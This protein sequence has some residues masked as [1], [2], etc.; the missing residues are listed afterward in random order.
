MVHINLKNRY[1]LK[2]QILFKIPQPVYNLIVDYF[3][4]CLNRNN[5]I[6]FHGPL[7]K[8]DAILLFLNWF[9]TYRVAREYG[10]K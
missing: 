4:Q 7:K 9:V 8:R 10:K 5:K 1:I 6:K 3:V 2:Q